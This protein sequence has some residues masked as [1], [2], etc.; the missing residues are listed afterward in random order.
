M[1]SPATRYAKYWHVQAF[2]QE[3]TDRLDYN[4]ICINFLIDHSG[5]GLAERGDRFTVHEDSRT[6]EFEWLP[7][8]R[9]ADE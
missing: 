4:E 9:L 5:N 8:E 6:Y 1:R 3:D 7:F 2:F